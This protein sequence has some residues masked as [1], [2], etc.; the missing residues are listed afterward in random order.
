MS[1]RSFE[2]DDIFG[3]DFRVKT[4]KKYETGIKKHSLDS[5]EEDDV[6]VNNVLNEDEFEGTDQH[7]V[8]IFTKRD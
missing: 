1:K 8:V 5:D 4:A 6:D 2:N 7:Y 3:R